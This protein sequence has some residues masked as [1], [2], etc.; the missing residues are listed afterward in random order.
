M[1]PP[2]VTKEETPKPEFTFRSLMKA[3]V[4]VV[5]AAVLLFWLLSLA[6]THRIRDVAAQLESVTLYDLDYNYTH[7]WPELPT[8]VSAPFPVEVFQR[9]AQVAELKHGLFSRDRSTL[10]VLTLKDGRKI[11]AAFSPEG[12]FLTFR[13]GSGYYPLPEPERAEFTKSYY[14][15]IAEH[16]VP[17]R[18]ERRKNATVSKMAPEKNSVPVEVK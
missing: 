6:G 8:A 10:V 3:V 16:F 17:Q 11:D 1:T 13:W 12:G 5:L 18:L 15:A 9:T 14:T 2:T 7:N 4:I